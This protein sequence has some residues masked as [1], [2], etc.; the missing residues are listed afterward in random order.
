MG[1]ANHALKQNNALDMPK[2]LSDGPWTLTN[3]KCLAGDLLLIFRPDNE[4]ISG[5]I[6]YLPDSKL[7]I[8]GRFGYLPDIEIQPDIRPVRGRNRISGAPLQL[9]KLRMSSCSLYSCYLE[10]L[11]G[12]LFRESLRVHNE[13]LEEKFEKKITIFKEAVQKSRKRKRTADSF[14]DSV[15]HQV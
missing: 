7:T 4:A 15:D 9:S 2:R 11:C 14:E 1:R 3:R 10:F 12:C 5:R 13:I 8:S 6:G